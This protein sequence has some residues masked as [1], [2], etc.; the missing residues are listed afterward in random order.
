MANYWIQRDFEEKISSL[1]AQRPA[2]VL[3]GPRQTGKTSILKRLFPKHHFVSLDL[4]TLAQQA[5]ENP[6]IFIKNHPLPLVIDE[7][8]YAPKL[9]RSLKILIDENRQA[10]GQ[11]ILTGSQKFQLMKEVS[12]SLAGRIAILDFDPLSFHEV[13]RFDGQLSIE[14][15]M[16]RGGFPEIYAADLEPF[17]FFQ[18]YVSSYLERD[19]RQILNVVHL[20]DFERFLRICA[21]RSG[22]ILNKSDLAKDIGMSPSTANQWLNALEASGIVKML[23][24]WYSNQ[25]K[26]MIKSPKIYINDCGLLCFLLNIQS[27]TE[28]RKSPLIGQIWETFIYGE[29]RKSLN[30]KD[31]SRNLFFWRDRSKEVDFLYHQGGSYTLGEVKYTSNP[32]K[33]H[34]TG[35]TYV[36]SLLGESHVASSYL[37]TRSRQRATLTKGIEACP[38]QDIA[39]LL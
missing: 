37:F 36:R 35:I 10:K 24:P 13:T 18:S 22:Q 20:R 21:L 30:L 33:S 12:E 28:L 8:Q 9:F 23:E 1:A 17:P 32:D 3:T 7:V 5:E 4:P 38:I 25:G 29:I 14:Q 19:L 27:E 26:R 31:R 34:A 11:L 6:E 2:L 39:G 15:C 16:L